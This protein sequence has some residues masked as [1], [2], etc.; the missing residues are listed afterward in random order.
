MKKRQSS[1]G[2]ELGKKRRLVCFAEEIGSGVNKRAEG[3]NVL[4]SIHTAPSNKKEK[5]I[6]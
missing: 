5:V 3:F 1:G 2:R 6:S 4:A